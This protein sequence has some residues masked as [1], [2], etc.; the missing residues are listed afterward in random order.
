M[1]KFRSGR[2]AIRAPGAR[3]ALIVGLGLGALIFKAGSERRP[4]S[5]V[6]HRLMEIQGLPAPVPLPSDK[7][8]VQE[9]MIFL[10]ARIKSDPEDFLALNMLAGC[11]LAR[12]RETGDLDYLERA[13][14]VVRKSL[15]VIPAERNLG[16]LASLTQVEFTSHE[17][18]AARD[19]A[20]RW[21]QIEPDS[22]AP[23][24]A[25]GDAQLE[26][27]QY[28]LAAK[29]FTKMEHFGGGVGTET[30]LARLSFLQ[31]RVADAQKHYVNAVAFALN[32]PVPPP[33][34]VAWSRWQLGETAFSFGDY[35][36]AEQHYRDSLTTCPGYFRALASLGRVRAARGDVTGAIKNYEEAIQAFPDPAF[37]A[38]LGDLY[39]IAGRN[40][41]AAAQYTLVEQIGLL[42]KASGVLYN[43][44]LALFY[45]DHGMKP[46][47]AY[48][49]AVSE[50]A[51]RR[52]IYG[53]DTVAWTALKAGKIEAARSAINQALRLGT[54]DA[55][56]YY[57]AG[58]IARAA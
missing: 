13:A 46:E 22:S 4:F 35:R 2:R 56:L 50:Y 58:M 26:L 28:D 21:T 37:V 44:Q 27:G 30:R 33:E 23:Y 45:A 42:T 34:A 38:A 29:A 7:E 39:K 57:H 52:D 53:A 14:R 47:A 41:D 48:R 43:R 55:K 10:T 8:S 16:G 12:Q 54:Q 25:L 18:A 17:F 6:T 32:M 5:P 24:G 11:Y 49:N 19:H 15:D 9:R 31:G 20:V 40:N 3:A 1:M 36:T 51:A